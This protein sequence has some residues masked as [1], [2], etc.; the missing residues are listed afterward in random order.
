MIALPRAGAGGD[1]MAAPRRFC[2]DR[3]FSAVFIDVKVAFNFEPMVPT[4]V[5]MAT[6]MPAAMRPY[7]IAVAPDSS[8]ANRSMSIL[9]GRPR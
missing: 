4:T 3:Y 6:E 7:S 9:M 5:M 1:L 8:L 2:D